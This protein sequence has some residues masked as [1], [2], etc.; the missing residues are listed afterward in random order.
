LTVDRRQRSV[1]PRAGG[2]EASERR[3]IAS[4][5]AREGFVLP[6]LIAKDKTAR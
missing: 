5:S 4:T 2:L 3:G 1:A 6:V